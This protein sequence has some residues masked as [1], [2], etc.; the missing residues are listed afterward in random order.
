[1][2]E[3]YVF[4]QGIQGRV[5]ETG[6]TKGWRAHGLPYEYPAKTEK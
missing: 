3:V 5:S 4:D 1:M 2:K 6:I